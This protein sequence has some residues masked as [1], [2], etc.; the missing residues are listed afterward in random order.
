VVTGF[1]PAD[2][3][4][5]IYMLVMQ[6]NRKSPEMEIQYRRAVTRSGNLIALFN[7]NEVFKR[8]DVHW[9]GIG[10][11]PLSGLTFTR[12]YE[13]FDADKLMQFSIKQ[14][15]ENKLCLCGEILRGKKIPPDCTLFARV[16]VP[17]NPVGACM[18]SSEGTCSTFYKFRQNG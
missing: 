4:Q 14:K 10:M 11:I 1:E 18:V 8:C 9:R 12:G 3:L 13:K 17:E 15:Q 16:C 5:A 6:V 7:M 2:I